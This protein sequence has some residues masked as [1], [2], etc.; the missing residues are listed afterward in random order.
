MPIFVNILFWIHLVSLSLGGAATFG[1]PVVGTMMP[2]ATAETRPTLFKVA[3]GLSN[4]SRVG[5][6]LLIITGPLMVWLKFGGT[7]GFNNWFWAKMV[8]VVL[9]LI[10]VIYAG[11]NAGRAEKG[12]MAAAKRAPMIGMTAMVLLLAV[13]FCAVFTFNPV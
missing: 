10:T 3:H 5:L 6:A 13:V 9:L 1:I 4:I 11:I 2:G 8:F 7:A 12:D